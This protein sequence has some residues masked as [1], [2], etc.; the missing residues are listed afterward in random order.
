MLIK[1]K[2]EPSCYIHSPCFF[3][4][5]EKTIE[6]CLSVTPTRLSSF[7]SNGTTNTEETVFKKNQTKNTNRIVPENIRGL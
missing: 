6:I 5:T 1:A 4:L 3:E 2:Q 7:I